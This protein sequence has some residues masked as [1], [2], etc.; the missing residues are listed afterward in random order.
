MKRLSLMIFG[1]LFAMIT[2][3]EA[4]LDIED[5][6]VGQSSSELL[7]PVSPADSQ[8]EP[9]NRLL[10]TSPTGRYSARNANYDIDVRLDPD[11]HMLE[12]RELLTWRND[13]IRATSELQ[14]H[15]YYNAWK[16]TKSTWMRESVSYTHLRAHET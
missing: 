10:L 12:G 14:F 1:M 13:S 5:P 9:V 8:H 7:Q 3:V 4:G 15:L 11:T 2:L 6:N 16:N